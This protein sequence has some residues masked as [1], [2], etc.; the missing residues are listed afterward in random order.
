MFAALFCSGFFFEIETTKL[1]KQKKIIVGDK[2]LCNIQIIILNFAKI[3]ITKYIHYAIVGDISL[4]EINDIYSK[5]RFQIYKFKKLE[6][7]NFSYSLFLN[8]DVCCIIL[9]KFEKL[10]ERQLYVTKSCAT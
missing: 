10:K 4:K 8:Q 6:T 2:Q 9:L 5:D 3:F 1:E 7:K